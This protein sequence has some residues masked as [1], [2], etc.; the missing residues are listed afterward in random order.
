MKALCA[1]L[2]LCACSAGT[3]V[4]GSAGRSAEEPAMVAAYLFNFG[5]FVQWPDA[6]FDGNKAPIEF[7]LYGDHPL[8]DH[9]DSLRGKRI[10]RR[11]VAIRRLQRGAETSGCHVL[12]ISASEQRYL[13]PL[14]REHSG[15][16]V[17]TV[18]E[19]GDFAALGGVIGLV[20][21]N[22]RLAFEINT[23]TA[24]RSSL[25]VSSQ[26]LKLARRVVHESDGGR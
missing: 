5:R 24:L 2:L 12:F 23:E 6:A 15:R 22:R 8:D 3:A 4:A 25:T 1:L 9:L 10:G 17:L 19:I 21:N 14:L 18:S 13:R 7:C 16:P 20:S 26:L 11:E